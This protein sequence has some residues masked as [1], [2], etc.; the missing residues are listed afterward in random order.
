MD[1]SNLPNTFES[2][3]IVMEDGKPKFRLNEPAFST[4]NIPLS[5]NLE[6]DDETSFVVLGQSSL[7]FINNASLIDYQQIQEKSMAVDYKSIISTLSHEEIE[8][9]VA[10]LLQE[11]VKLKEILLQNNRSMKGQ[12]NKLMSWQEELMKVHE[13]HKHKFSETRNMIRLLQEE[14]MELKTKLTSTESMM[15]TQSSSEQNSKNSYRL[16]SARDLNAE[17]MIKHVEDELEN[18]SDVNMKQLLELNKRQD[19]D[20][21]Y[22]Q[23]IISSLKAQLQTFIENSFEPIKLQMNDVNTQNNKNRQQFYDNFLHYNEKLSSVVKCYAAQTSRF[24]NIQDCLKHCID[25]IKTID[26]NSSS[27]VQEKSIQTL[28]NCRKQLINEQLQNISERQNLIM[29]QN[30]FQKIFSDYNSALHELE[31]LRE[32][33][34]KPI[35]KLDILE[36]EREELMEKMKMINDEK[37]QLNSAKEKLIAEQISF[38]QQQAGLEEAKASLNSQSMLYETEMKTLQDNMKVMEKRHDNMLQLSTKLKEVLQEKNIELDGIKARLAIAKNDAETITILK[39]QLDLYKSDFE[40]EQKAKQQLINERE[41]LTDQ[42]G[43]LRDHNQKLLQRINGPNPTSVSQE[44]SNEHL[45]DAF[46]N[47]CGLYKMP[48]QWHG[49][50]FCQPVD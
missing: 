11:N 3:G 41:F 24:T 7:D 47:S 15:N 36:Q 16:E 30:Q 49:P 1:S 12:F 5:S 14:N 46:C 34:G 44:E 26:I 21:H 13:S 19:R 27:E 25:V 10:E 20:L 6:C 38:E 9:K 35:E 18:T 37:Q 45:A 17:F 4:V 39:Q 28:E 50:G 40:E 23:E 48:G 29:A 43:K 32:E 42:L 31:L 33:N 22:R 2:L 8:S